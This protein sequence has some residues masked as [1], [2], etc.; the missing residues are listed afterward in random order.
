MRPE[1]FYLR[2]IVIA[3]RNAHRFAAAIDRKEFEKSDLHH[4]AIQYNLLI[5]GE[6]ASK[7][8]RGLRSRHKNVDWKSLKDFRNTNFL[9]TLSHC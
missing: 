7:I 3:C 4:A 6:A 5:I 9:Y 2:D 8:S 1:E